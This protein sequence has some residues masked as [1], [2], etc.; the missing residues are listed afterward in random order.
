MIHLSRRAV[1]AVPL[2]ALSVRQALGRTGF[3]AVRL[4][5]I[6]AAVERENGGRLGVVAVNHATGAAIGHRAN[7]RFA[8]CSTFK[9]LVASLILSRADQSAERL[10]RRLAVTAADILPHS[11]RTEPNV[12]R[13]M[14]VAELC[15]AIMTV[16]DNAA[17]N[18]LLRALGGPQ[19]ITDHARSL[20]DTVTRLD[21]YEPELNIVAG[22]EVR[23]TTTPAAMADL[24][25][26]VALGRLLKDSSRKTLIGWMREASTGHSRLRAGL[27]ADWV[28]GDKTGSG[29]NGE[30]NDIAAVWAPD[31]PGFAVAAYYVRPGRTTEENAAVL[32]QVGRVVSAM[33]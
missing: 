32:A 9:F 17:A 20:G 29:P 21:R 2:A 31:G 22:D 23:D 18:I 5:G 8:M 33:I 10:D 28:A 11:P 1:L 6:L 12:G 26:K 14:S 19:S 27:P 16:S 30:V 3:D 7:E 4:S 15:H 13:T 25:R 24:I